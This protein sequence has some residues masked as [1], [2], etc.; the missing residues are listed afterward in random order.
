EPET[1]YA[2]ISVRSQSAQRNPGSKAT[3]GKDQRQQE[4]AG[5]TNSKKSRCLGLVALLI[6]ISLFA[7]IIGL[8]VYVLKKDLHHCNEELVQRQRTIH[9]L[10][11]AIRICSDLVCPNG[12][13][14]H[15]QSC[16][17]SSTE[18]KDWD[19]ANRKCESQN[20]QLLIIN[21]QQ[22]QNF[23]N[24][25]ILDTNR[26]YLMGLT[27]RESE[28]NWIWVDGTP[29]SLSRW[30]S[31]EPNNVGN[32][33]CSVIRSS[34]W[35]DVSCSREFPFICEKRAPSCIGAADFEKYCP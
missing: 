5:G 28:G 4:T 12:W 35:N 11:P 20:S 14:F 31:N 21:S 8:T 2:Q 10:C 7:I 3:P 33:D 6:I 27:D 1:T 24:R 9:L 17:R 19:T 32:E 30:S 29:V 34:G 25:S 16:Y 18:K 22:E 26:Q 15:N 23:V 13:K